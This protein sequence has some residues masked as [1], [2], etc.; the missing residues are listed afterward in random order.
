MRHGYFALPVLLLSPLIFYDQRYYLNLVIIAL[1]WAIVAMNWDI[2]FGYSGIWSFG[3]LGFFGIGCYA[4]GILAIYWGVSPWIGTMIGVALSVMIGTI[5]SFAA[6]R[7]KKF[8]FAIVTLGFLEFVKSIL[9]V[10]HPKWL[11]PIPSYQIGPL[12]FHAFNDLPNYYLICA[13][14]LL[15]AFSGYRL[16]NSRIGLALKAIRDN[17]TWAVSLGVNPFRARFFAFLVSCVFTSI[18]G[19][20]YGHYLSIMMI[21][22]TLGWGP[23]LAAFLMLA[24]GGVGTFWGPIGGAFIWVALSEFLRVV[25]IWRFVIMA[26]A[27]IVLFRIVPQGLLRPVTRILSARKSPA[28]TR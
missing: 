28:P 11:S 8:Y 16:V 3:Q 22:S 15:S 6:L 24:I 5:I 14:F 19:S 26:A 13:V 21:S 20:F 25:D 9:V 4:S 7:L 27:A 18:A 2:L 17:E 12:D 1:M 10:Y 23:M